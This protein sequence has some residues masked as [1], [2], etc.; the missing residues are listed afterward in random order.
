MSGGPTY[1][2]FGIPLVGCDDL[3]EACGR[4]ACGRSVSGLAICARCARDYD[5]AAYELAVEQF[6][7][8][9]R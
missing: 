1:F 2:V 6:P 4:K 3:C 8:V 9:L 7:S 5:R